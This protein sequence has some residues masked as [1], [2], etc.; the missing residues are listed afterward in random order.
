MIVLL[1]SSLVLVLGL[2]LD[3]SPSSSGGQGS[4]MAEPNEKSRQE[5]LDAIPEEEPDDE[6]NVDNVDPSAVER[7]DDKD[8]LGDLARLPAE[9]R[10]LIYQQYFFGEGVECDIRRSTKDILRDSSGD[11]EDNLTTK[12]CTV[13]HSLASNISG[14]SLLQTNKRM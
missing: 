4:K 8:M 7:A 11:R 2:S 9:L 14:V 13:A 5:T 12:P 1:I 10:V 6:N 3:S